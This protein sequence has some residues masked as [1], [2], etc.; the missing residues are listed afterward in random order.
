[1]EGFSDQT[2][3]QQ[4]R[5]SGGGNVVRIRLSNLDGTEPL[6][7]AEATI[8]ESAGGAGTK[9][10]TM[11]SLTFR[12]SRSVTIPAGQVTASD[13][14]GLHVAPLES[15]TVTLYFARPHR[16]VDLPRRRP[17]NHLPGHRRPCPRP[18]S[19]GLRRA[20]QPLVLLPDRSGRGHPRPP[21]QSWRSGTPSPTAT[22]P[23]SAAMT[24]TPTPWPNG[25]SRRTAPGPSPMPGS[26]ATCCCTSS[27][28][29][30]R[31]ESPDS[32][33]TPSTSPESAPSS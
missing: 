28:A 4:V 8:A 13:A 26:P 2:V 10:G 15:L 18:R 3:R 31:P 7:I 21:R 23:P 30:A 24:G 11:R 33:A 29:S 19:R 9:P 6:R 32:S 17:D 25:S 1:M 12:G 14:A 27:P 16:S 5:V 22:T 20:Y